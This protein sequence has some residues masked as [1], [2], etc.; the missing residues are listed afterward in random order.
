MPF[1]EFWNFDFSNT[2]MTLAKK[3]LG[4]ETS[5]LWHKFHSKAAFHN[6]YF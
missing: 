6:L 3:L 2:L 4:M 5:K 1:C